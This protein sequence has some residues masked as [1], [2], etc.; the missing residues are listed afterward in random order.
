MFEIVD[1]SNLQENFFHPFTTVGNRNFSFNGYQMRMEAATRQRHSSGM[2]VSVPS[3][4]L[5]ILGGSGKS[6]RNKAVEI[7]VGRTWQT[8]PSLPTEISLASAQ[9]IGED[10][11]IFG[12][13]GSARKTNSVYKLARGTEKWEEISPK[14]KSV[15]ASHMSVL[16]GSKGTK[17]RLTTYFALCSLPR[18]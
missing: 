6:G 5:M 8:G 9:A 17:I 18:L 16:V 2:L 1:P 4:G 13:Q 15:R 11:F 14:L 12:G 10:L 7:L 3:R